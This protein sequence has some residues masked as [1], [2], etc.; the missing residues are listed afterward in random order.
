[1]RLVCTSFSVDVFRT[2]T[3]CSRR[4]QQKFVALLLGRQIVILDQAMAVAFDH[5]QPH[6]GMGFRRL[7]AAGACRQ[8][9]AMRAGANADIFALP[10][11]NEV[12][13]GLR[14]GRHGFS[15]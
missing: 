4:H 9:P 8:D 13:P 5:G 12:V 2:G 1:M 6:F 3:T 10:P 15:D 11:I 7:C 14:A